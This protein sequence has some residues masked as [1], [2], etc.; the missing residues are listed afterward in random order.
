[1]KGRS[2]GKRKLDRIKLEKRGHNT[3]T[4]KSLKKKKIRNDYYYDCNAAEHGDDGD[5]CNRNDYEEDDE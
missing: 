5:Y 1:M 2:K 4:G 3:E